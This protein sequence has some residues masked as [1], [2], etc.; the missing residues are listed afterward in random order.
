MGLNEADIRRVLWTAGQA[1]LAVFL[2]AATG[3]LNAPNLSEAKAALV[4]GAVA[5]LA[6][7]L[8]AIKNLLLPDSST[9]K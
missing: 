3:A 2:V 8:S 5:G 1:F 7:A 4:A 9:L 6:A